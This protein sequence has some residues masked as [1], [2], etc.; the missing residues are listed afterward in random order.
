MVE[1]TRAYRTHVYKAFGDSG[2]AKGWEHYRSVAFAAFEPGSTEI[3]DRRRDFFRRRR[4][5]TEERCLFMPGT[6][7]LLTSR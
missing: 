3:R 4:F 7:V 1:A 5:I 2:I 6:A